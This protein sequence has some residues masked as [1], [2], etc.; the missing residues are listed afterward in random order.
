MQQPVQFDTH[1][2][3]SLETEATVMI[4]SAIAIAAVATVVTLASHKPVAL[5]TAGENVR[6]IMH[7]EPQGDAEYIGD[8][9]T[10]ALNDLL[11]VKN[12]LRNQAARLGGNL[13]VIDTIQPE[14]FQGNNWGYSGS[15][16][17]YYLSQNQNM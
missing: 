9:Q 15:G 13:L 2:D 1:P 3:T 6:L 11:S 7:A 17:V 10:K 16:R 8:I 5:T 4:L 14:I 12:D